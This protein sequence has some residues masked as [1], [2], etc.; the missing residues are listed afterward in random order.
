MAAT[1]IVWRFVEDFNR[2]ILGIKRD[3]VMQMDSNESDDLV[4]MMEEEIQEFKD[5]LNVV[6]DV[7]ALIDLIYFAVGGM[8]KSGLSVEQMHLCFRAVHEANMT[9]ALGK[10]ENRPDVQGT[11]AA[12]PD[13]FV[14]PKHTIAQ[15]LGV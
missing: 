15:I 2:K 3:E 13:D 8:V 5:S 1:T 14:D 11:D 7:D 12:K 9:K 4:I 6:D 10:K